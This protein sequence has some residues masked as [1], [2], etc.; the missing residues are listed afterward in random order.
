MRIQKKKLILVRTV[1]SVMLLIK[2]MTVTRHL[3]V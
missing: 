3:K 1:N 2:A